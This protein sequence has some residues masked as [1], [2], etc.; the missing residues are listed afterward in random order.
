MNITMGS[1]YKEADFTGSTYILTYAE[2]TLELYKKSKK[3][4]R[5][6]LINSRPLMLREQPYKILDKDCF[7]ITVNNLTGN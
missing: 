5:K 2:R 3:A 6:A 4:V 7:E 1:L